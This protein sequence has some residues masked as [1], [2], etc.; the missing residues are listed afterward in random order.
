MALALPDARGRAL[1]FAA[2][3]ELPVGVSKDVFMAGGC[4]LKITAGAFY[5]DL[6]GDVD[7]DDEAGMEAFLGRW[8]DLF[9]SLQHG[10][11][12]HR[13]LGRVFGELQAALQLLCRLHPADRPS[14]DE[15][16]RLLFVASEWAPSRRHPGQDGARVE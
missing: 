11:S 12:K 9:A 8:L 1:W 16:L 3:D 10:T 7:H 14:V 13:G 5:P 2:A 15:V 6:L 4:V